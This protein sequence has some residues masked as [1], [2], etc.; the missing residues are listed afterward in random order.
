MRLGWPEW[1]AVPTASVCVL[2]LL[3]PHTAVAQYFNN[4]CG[5]VQGGFCTVR[6][7]PVGSPCG[8]FTPGGLVQGQIMAPGGGFQSMPILSNACRTFRGICQTDPAPIGSDCDCFGDDGT[9]IPR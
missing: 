6:P 1:R 4:L 9:V 7:A 5:T 8:C 3:I 2:S